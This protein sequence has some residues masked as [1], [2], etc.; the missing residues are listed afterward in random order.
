MDYQVDAH[1]DETCPQITSF[2]AIFDE[3]LDPEECTASLGLTPDVMTR[4]IKTGVY[5]PGGKPHFK[6]ASWEIRLDKEPAW[7]IETG[8]CKVIDTIWPHREKIIDYLSSTGFQAIFGSNVTIH[9]S[10]PLY[11]LSPETLGRMATLGA[12]FSLDIFDYSE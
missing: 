5:L 3:D 4:A 12:E 8:L 7:E 10:R 2:F 11:I 6:K 9:A 1:D